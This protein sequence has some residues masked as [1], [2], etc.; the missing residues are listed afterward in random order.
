M[1]SCLAACIAI[2][3]Y[4][5]HDMIIRS[6]KRSNGRISWNNFEEWGFEITELRSSNGKTTGNR[7]DFE[8]A[9][10]LRLNQVRNIEGRLCSEIPC[11]VAPRVARCLGTWSCFCAY[12]MT[13]TV[14]VSVR[15]SL[16]QTLQGEQ[17]QFIEATIYPPLPL[18]ESHR[19]WKFR[20][21]E[22]SQGHSRSHA[23]LRSHADW[24]KWLRLK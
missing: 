15:F 1:N 22:S 8:I 17:Y 14:P 5:A 4:N 3:V 11:L 9:V 16:T 12:R 19:N 24:A 7:F 20:N 2:S 18:P 13:V 10:R 6:D 21:T 23:V